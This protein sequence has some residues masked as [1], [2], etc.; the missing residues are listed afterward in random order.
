MSTN[1]PIA[2]NLSAID[3][4]QLDQHHRNGE[5]VFGTIREIREDKNGYAFKLPAETG[6]IQRL[7][8]FIA[9]ERLCC[10]FFEFSLN[11]GAGQG[12]VWLKLSGREGVKAYI[13]ETLLPRLEAPITTSN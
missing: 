1:S 4:E 7:G 6:L 9:R 2:C 8:S 11:I 13:K 3:K 5:A 12:P 10:P